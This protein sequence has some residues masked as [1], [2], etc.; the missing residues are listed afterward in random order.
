MDCSVLCSFKMRPD[1]DYRVKLEYDRSYNR[2]LR[3]PAYFSPVAIPSIMKASLSKQ[4]PM[5]SIPMAS[6]STP[7]QDIDERCSH[8]LQHKR[9]SMLA[10]YCCCGVRSKQTENVGRSP[11][12]RF[13]QHE[14]TNRSRV[15]ISSAASA[16]RC[17]TSTV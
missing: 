11:T 1:A 14:D 17:K 2:L 4:S 13:T 12:T 7:A 9:Y 6:A 5:A 8:L 10:D 3:P 15:G 16:Q